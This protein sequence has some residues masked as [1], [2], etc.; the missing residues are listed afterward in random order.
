MT[1]L[2]FGGDVLLL[3]WSA[4]S[5]RHSADAGVDTFV[6]RNGMIQAQTVRY[7]LRPRS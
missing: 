4:E 5:D 1:D 7:V 2:V 3:E 6:F